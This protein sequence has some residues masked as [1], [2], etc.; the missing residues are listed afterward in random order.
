MQKAEQ[1]K[2]K[3]EQIAQKQEKAM[4]KK[5]ANALKKTLKQE[6]KKE[7]K[8]NKGAFTPETVDIPVSAT[9]CPIEKVEA[10]NE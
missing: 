5:A 9:I 7:K 6:E 1:E 10:T 8:L 4:A 3:Q 2:V